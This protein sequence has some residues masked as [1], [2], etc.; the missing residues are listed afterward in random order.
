MRA[1]WLRTLP[2]ALCGAILLAG[3][4]KGTHRSAGAPSKITPLAAQGAV[5]VVTRNTT[6]LGGANPTTDA[7]SV[8]RTV[9]PALTPASR[10]QVVVLV[11]E[12]NWPAALAASSLA[13]APAAAPIL[14]ANGNTLP[15][16]TLQTL[17]VLAP[18]GAPTLSGVQVLRIG[19]SAPVPKGMLTRDLP[20]TQPALEALV[21]ERL[22]THANAS[23]PHQ[24]IVVA[25]KASPSASMPA[26]GLSAESGAPILFVGRTSVPTQTAAA[27]KSLKHPSIYVVDPADVAAPALA[28]LRR[29]GNVTEIGPATQGHEHVANAITIARFAD[30]QFGWGVKE[31]GH[32]LVFVNGAR[33]L[34]GPAAA[35]LSATGD[36]GPLLILDSA[37]RV[38]PPLSTYL[39]DIQPAYTDNFDF[40]PVRGVYNHGWLIGDELAISAIVQAQIDG[41]LQISPRKSSEEPSVSQIE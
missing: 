17:R 37:A 38:A 35:P 9:Y 22:L 32:G 14:F 11:D 40:R 39:T 19:T 13:S 15:D 7:A 25:E 5:S 28:A 27:L 34:D 2:F 20:A 26:A 33:P 4:G 10:P 24:V 41:L 8:A 30:A 3:C 36:Y 16:V 31:P 21:I 18:R 29:F 23:T 12:H 1:A 6:R